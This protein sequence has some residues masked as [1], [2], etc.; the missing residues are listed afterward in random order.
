MTPNK[1]TTSANPKKDVL[2]IDAEDD[3]TAIIGKVKTSKGSIVALVPPKRIGVLQSAVN[4]RLLSRAAHTGKKT[5][6]IITGNQALTGLAAAAKIPVAKSLQSK[7]EIAE[8]PALMIDGGEDVIDGAEL[9]IGEHA[10]LKKDEEVTTNK[11]DELIPAAAG[12][13]RAKKPSKS[14]RGPKVPDFSSFRKRLLL[15]GGLVG[16]LLIFTV[17]AIWFAPRAT[18]VLSAQTNTSKV[19]TGIELTTS[20]ETSV[21]EGTL[22]AIRQT[23]TRKESVRFEPTGEDNRGDKAT[24]RVT[25][26]TGSPGGLGTIPAGT[27]LASSSGATFRTD[28]DVTLGLSNFDGASVSIT[29]TEPGKKFNG[30]TGGMS[31]APENVDAKLNDATSGGTDKIVAVVTQGD[32]NKAKQELGAK[33]ED[34]DTDEV[35]GEMTFADDTIVIQDS[36]T[37][38][39][40]DMQAEPGLD[41]EA[42]GDATV[43]ASVKYTMYGVAKSELQEYLDAALKQAIADQPSQRVYDNGLDGAS[44]DDFDADGNTPQV[45]LNA[46]GRVGPGIDEEEIKERVRGKNYG[47]VQADLEAINGI[48]QADTKFWPFWVNTVPDDPDKISIEFKL[49]DDA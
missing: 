46:E 39:T 32:I 44:I 11:T 20:G 45:T 47:D 15:I 22:R 48:Q 3:I 4:L 17:W 1:S 9:S 36:L 16:A 42:S 38:S 18:V 31:G 41:Q 30:A 7:P 6:V 26:S 21:E 8:I 28:N 49:N 43:S 23:V 27:E 34:I 37:N 14:S 40:S 33:L 35:Q 19:S 24:G 12:V 5:L 2:Y 25:F 29:A 10:G 13:T